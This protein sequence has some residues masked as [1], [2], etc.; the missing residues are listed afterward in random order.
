MELA[1]ILCL[2]HKYTD[3]R[4]LS[5]TQKFQSKRQVTSNT[6]AVSLEIDIDTQSKQ[7]LRDLLQNYQP[8]DDNVDQLISSILSELYTS[9]IEIRENIRH[10]KA[11]WGPISITLESFVLMEQARRHQQNAD[12]AANSQYQD[13]LDQLTQAGR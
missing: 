5:F 1:F 2:I 9:H 11:V 4:S 8:N 13:L 12:S 3:A 10:Q 7:E 6:E